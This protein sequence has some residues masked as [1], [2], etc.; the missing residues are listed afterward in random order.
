MKGTVVATWINTCRKNFNSK[1]VNNAMEQVGWG[2]DRVFSP[3]ENVNDDEVKRIIKYIAD[4]E[5][6][7]IKDLW[8]IIGKDNIKTFYENFPAFFEHEN[9]YSFLKSMYDVHVVM[10]TKFPGAKPPLLTI[11]PISKNE[12]IFTY[13]SNRKM[14]DYFIGL[15]EGVCDHFNEKIQFEEVTREDGYLELKL[16][17][18]EDI[19]YKKV[20]KLN[21]VLSLGFVKS[22]GIKI[23]IVTFLATFIGSAIFT[24]NIISSLS[25]SLIASI[26]TI[27]SAS[28][29]NRPINKIEESIKL[30]AEKNY[31]ENTDIFTGDVYEGM[32]ST[33]KEVKASTLSDI[34]EYKGLADEM[35]T[36]SSQLIKIA[37]NMTTTSHEVSSVV[38]QVAEASSSQAMNIDSISHILNENINYLNQLVD[39]EN[40]NKESLEKAVD[41]IE[42][43]HK[44][45]D[46]IS[47]SILKS[48]DEFEK[49]KEQGERLENK[50]KDINNIVSIVSGI[51]EQ[52]N[53]LALNASIEAARAGDQGR[54]FAV[55][56]EEVRKLAEQSKMAVEEINSNLVEFVKE[57]GSLV[58]STESQFKSLENE[59]KELDGLKESSQ[60]SAIS[61]KSVSE[62]I[63]D[64][65]DKLNKQASDITGI[66]DNIE[67]LAAISEENSAASQEVSANI[68]N[69]T[70][71]IGKLTSSIKEFE[72]ISSEFKG[73]L[74]KYKM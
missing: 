14:F 30:M 67:A 13:K 49:V 66:Y 65:I 16:T 41:G 24:Q 5:K 64:T 48:I 54:G 1:V 23:G 10:T 37:D 70:N 21:K 34:I 58:R 28:M 17:F 18:E 4:T 55:V 50:A 32:Y 9:A 56:A 71:Q 8:K 11:H 46:R 35:V 40:N 59:S 26:F 15:F 45:F 68:V 63:I 29:L 74:K 72:K 62:V 19:Y 25:I 44:S 39:S 6:I 61:I 69:Y 52:T 27:I 20:Y 43:N 7:D 60:E 22:I 51:S 42:D 31:S 36:F 2:A 47:D 3:V 73:R 12:A 53:L 33:I 38:E 57:I